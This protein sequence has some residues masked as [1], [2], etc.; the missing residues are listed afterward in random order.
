MLCDM[1][2]DMMWC[3][4]V[5]CDMLCGVVWCVTCCGV[6]V[7]CAGEYHR[8]PVREG[9]AFSLCGRPQEEAPEASVSD[10]LSAPWW[11]WYTTV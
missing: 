2:C 10:T 3:G 5:V 9:P 4:G 1:L 8:D 6:V 7:W 11:G